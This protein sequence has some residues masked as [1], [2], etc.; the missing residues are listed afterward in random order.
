MVRG[1]KVMGDKVEEPVTLP[2]LNLAAF[3][4]QP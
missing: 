1:N 2:T 3:N 4:L